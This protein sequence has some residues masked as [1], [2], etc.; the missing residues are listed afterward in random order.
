MRFRVSAALA[1]FAL[2]LALNPAEAQDY[3]SRP[4]KIV[5]PVA[6]GGIADIVA[7]I[8][9]ARLSEAGHTA[10]VENRAGGAGVVAAEQVAKSAPDGYTLLLGHHGVLSVLQHLTK[11]NY[12]PARDFVPVVHFVTVPNIL[13][14]H[15]S[16]PAKDV[17][18]LIAHAKANPGKLSYASQGVG[19]TGHI[20]GE[21]FKQA[22]GI[23]I[24]H[25]P[26]KG[27]APAA[28]DLVA[29]HVSMMF[30]V[31][32]L[33]LGSIKGGQVRAIGLAAP[34][35]VSVLPDLPTLTEQG[36][37]VTISAYFGLVAPAGTPTPV[38]AWLNREANKTF[39]PAEARERFTSQGAFMPMGTS[40]AFGKFIDAETKQYGEVI[41]RSAI[42]ME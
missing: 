25:V 2:A 13:V 32:S 6:P 33:A 12:D 42:R 28:Q 39:A 38:L 19:A 27:A 20:A 7:R 36:L 15:P 26:Y 31:V 34:E 4:I 1:V 21:L 23:E 37:P 40:E 35:R 3:P 9:A 16:V 22:A 18:E 5:V 29:G 10:I 11:L 24:T 30:D 17:R 8:Y 41:R 14:V